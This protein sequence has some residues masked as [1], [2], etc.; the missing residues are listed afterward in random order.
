[1][2]EYARRYYPDT[3][4]D[5]N[6]SSF[7]S[8]ML[9]TVAYVGD[10]LSF[11]TDYQANESFLSTAMEYDNVIKLSKQYGYKHQP[12]PSSYGVVSFFVLIPTQVGTVAPDRDYMPILKSGSKFSTSAGSM[13]TLLDDV[14]FSQPGNEL[15]VAKADPDTGAPTRYAVRGYGQVISGEPAIQKIEVGAFEKF[16]RFKVAG[17]NISEIISVNDSHG[18]I[19][20]EVDYLS[21]NVIY[22]PVLNQGSDRD[23][24]RNI[25]KP[26]TVPRRFIV[27]QEFFNTFIQFG[28]GSNEE[29]QELKN[30][31]EVILEQHGKNHVT[32]R[33]FDPSVLIETDKMGVAPSNTVLTVVY[34]VNTADNVNA[35]VGA[36]TNVENVTMRFPSP[37]AL[38]V[39]KMQ[40]VRGS[41]E[42]TN[43]IPI[44]GDI[45]LI[46]SD[47]IKERTKSAF[48][49][50][51]RAVTQQDYISMIYQMPANFGKIYRAT[52]AQDTSSFNSRNLNLYLVSED[53]SGKLTLTNPTMKQN[54]KTW[55]NR[56]KM[57]N[58]TIDIMDAKII[59]LGVEFVANIAPGASKYTTHSSI[60]NLLK[61]YFLLKKF[62]IG[63]PISISEI[64]QLISADTGIL[65]VESVDFT[66]QSGAEYFD[67]PFPIE[68]MK[69][70]TGTHITPP[71]DGIFEI[72]YPARDIKG[73]IK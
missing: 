8:L 36:L 55:V 70:P 1:L 65:D 66:L 31:S 5:F 59:N 63:E 27:E 29:P 72:R 10:M 64:W 21:Q 67:A 2:V 33:T 56:Y 19:Y 16:A 43:E 58:D 7:G 25:L 38:T 46:T 61:G 11:Y 53:E 48:A 39:A 49:T 37:E 9:D 20:Y 69:N 26:I 62:D 60:V 54:V 57:I 44:V 47:E 12:N 3:F 34:R 52:A 28:A 32:D 71:V 68:D 23:T 6:E 30:P 40:A 51:N 45:S 14:D 35:P 13:F 22:L 41:L 15:V 50:Q 24:V 42:L 17:N 73:T 18:N 4:K